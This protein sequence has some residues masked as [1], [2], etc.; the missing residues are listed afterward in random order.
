MSDSRPPIPP[1]WELDEP[2]PKRDLMDFIASG[3]VVD[4]D[5]LRLQGGPNARLYGYD[6]FESDQLGYLPDGGTVPLGQLSTNALDGLITPQ[7]DVRGIGKQTFGRPVVVTENGGFDN[8]LPLLWQGQGLAAPDYLADDPERRADYLEAERLGRLNQQ[9]AHA[10]QFMSP[11]AFRSA[12]RWG[13]KLRPDESVAFTS[14][15]PELRPEFQRLT[16]AEEQ[17]YFAFLAGQSGNPNFGQADLDAYWKSK[18]KVAD[19]ASANFIAAIRKG[20]RIGNIDY[21]SWDA[22]TLADFNKQNAF[23]GMRPEVQ[24]AYGAL[25]SDPATTAEQLKQFADVNGMTFDPRDVSAFFDARAKGETAPIPLPLIDPGDGRTGAAARGFGDPLGFLDEM[26]GVVDAIGGT[27]YR[28]SIWNSDRSFGDIYENN[29]RQ[30][31]A[32][33]DYDETNYPWWRF[34]GQMVSGAALPGSIG[35]R[36]VAGYAKAGGAIGGVYGF[37][38]ADG[39]IGDRFLNVPLNAAGGAILG[40]TLGKGFEVGAPLLQ[41]GFLRARSAFGPPEA[42]PPFTPRLPDWLNIPAGEAQAPPLPAVG[43]PVATAYPGPVAGRPA[44]VDDV[45]AQIAR[46]AEGQPAGTMFHGSP[47]AGITEFDPYGRADYGLFGQGTYLTDNPSIAASYSAKGMKVAGGPEGRTLYGVQQTVK[48]PIDM[49]APADVNAWQS[50][51]NDYTD[52]FRPGMTNEEAFREVE[53]AISQEGLP[54]WEGAE[55]MNDV[56]RRMGHDGVTH[57]GGGRFGRGDGPR[58]RVVIALEPEQTSIS[59]SLSLGDLMAPKM[60]DR[61]WIDVNDLPPIPEGFELVPPSRANMSAEPDPSLAGPRL[62]DSFDMGAGRPTPL[63]GPIS[64]QRLLGNAERVQ[65]GDVLPRQANEVQSLEEFA[66]ANDG[67]YPDVRAPNERDY[68]DT[69]HFPSRANP[70]NMLPRKGP[71]DLVGF[72]RSQGGMRDEAGELTAAGLSNAARKGDDFTQAESRLGP[73]IDN[74]GGAAIEDMAQRAWNEGYFPELDRPPTPQEFIAA[75]DDTYRGVGRRFRPQDE[76]EIRS[77]EGARDQRL[78]VER[79]QQEGAPLAEDLGQPATYDDIV[80]NTPPATAYDDWNNA[81]VSKVGNIRVDKLNSAE[82]IGQALKVAD[83]VAGGFDAARRGQISHAETQALARDLGMT[84]DDLLARRSGQALNAEEAYAARAILDKSGKELVAMARR[85]QRSGDAPGD[86]LLAS[87]RKA[88]VRHTA[89]QEQVAGATAEAGRALSAFRM[90]ADSRDVP[91]RVL[92]ELVNAGGGSRR[93]KDAA[94]AIVDLEADPA[95]LNRFVEKASKPRFRDKLVEL[96]INSLLSGPQTHVVNMLSNTLTSIAQIP[97]HAAAAGIGA[98]RRLANRDALDRVTFSEVGSRAV[99]MLQGAKE[100]AREFARALRT[101]EASDFVSK[102]EDQGQKAISGLKGEIV[103][104]PTRFLTAEDE[105]FKGMARR[106]ELTGLAMRKAH[107]EGLKGDALRARSAELLA[108]PTDDMI[109]SAMDYGRYVTFQRPLGEIAGPVS[110]AT[111][112]APILKLILPFVRTPTNLFKFGIERSPAAPLLKEWRKDFAAGGAKR[113][114]ALAR[115]MVGSGFGA[116]FA[117]MAANGLITGSPPSDQNRLRQL[118]ASGWQE[119]SVKLG[120]TYYSYKRLDPFALTIGAAA[121]MATLGDGMTEAEREEGAGLIVASILGNLSNKTWLSGVSDLMEALSDPERSGGTFVKRLA[122]SLAVPTGVSQVARWMD[123][124]MREAPDTL[125]YIQSRIPGLSDDLLPRRDMWGQ[126]I[127]SQGGVGP[128]VL[129]PIW[130]SKETG[131]PVVDALLADNLKVG[132]LSRRVGG[133]KLSDAK[134]NRYQAL[135]GPVLRDEIAKL[136][137]EPSWSQLDQ[138]DKQDELDKTAKASRAIARELLR[139]VRSNGSHAP[140]TPD[141]API[142][143]I[144]EG[145]ELAQ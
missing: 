72:V 123:P 143:P 26:G 64:D 57:I 114:L 29:L 48:N 51:A 117:E 33:I 47:R 2:D 42:V 94:N 30:N 142:P 36:G 50:A 3:G 138:E 80:A 19:T 106:M 38:S 62:P 107:S 113:D 54:K 12:K 71:I 122:G 76:A 10:T 77:F 81:V 32:I 85:I 133:Q 87:F 112:D 74:E 58:H 82:D 56:I 104:T 78:A 109:E 95:N 46:W 118:R 88:L 84:A 98:A 23:A 24:Q 79:A 93:L 34:G 90:A 21:S 13:L 129:S 145:F 28:E 141:S 43:E 39:N 15:L 55:M 108:N 20:E 130:T 68:L 83:N 11:D 119:Y 131:D 105:L 69:R 67:L 25:L 41:R 96:W 45:S 1:G 136:L 144:P 137:S 132:K 35:V 135:A 110:R 127:V 116:A 65:P 63:L 121:D 4:G 18:G 49:D 60:R 102:V 70:E 89:I 120:D 53:A 124:T 6:A 115:A 61:D 139:G 103:R 5:T 16:D 100:G 40:G 91:G 17:E 44:T 59:D 73:V 101:G 8:V 37:G 27:P 134:Y 9:G 7:T 111:Q 86:E 75:V 22:A 14:E 97:E 140:M 31:R 128:D 126:P 99:G 125:S 92:S 52:Q 66:A